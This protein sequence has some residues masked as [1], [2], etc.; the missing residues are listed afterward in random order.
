[1]L[2]PD[3]GHATFE[4]GLAQQHRGLRTGMSRTDDHDIMGFRHLL[5]SHTTRSVGVGDQHGP[6]RGAILAFQLSNSQL[7]CLCVISTLGK[8]D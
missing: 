2:L 5:L 4:T 8:V 6:E 3:Q 7:V 1:L